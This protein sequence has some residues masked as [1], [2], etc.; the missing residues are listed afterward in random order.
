MKKCSTIILHVCNLPYFW[1]TEITNATYFWIMCYITIFPI[2]NALV[3]FELNNGIQ[4][5]GKHR[6]AQNNNKKFLFLKSDIV[7]WWT[8]QSN[9]STPQHSDV[10]RYP[11]TRNPTLWYPDP[12]FV[13]QKPAIIL[14]TLV[15]KIWNLGETPNFSDTQPR[16]DLFFDTWPEPE[17]FLPY[18]I[19]KSRITFWTKI[20]FHAL[21]NFFLKM[22]KKRRQEWRNL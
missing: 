18:Y 2:M 5:W 17:F 9:A 14:I 16:P 10:V 22:Q 11:K 21:G 20:L 15:P 12:N 3:Y 7:L 6:V 19:I 4:Y 13:P 1:N 8:R